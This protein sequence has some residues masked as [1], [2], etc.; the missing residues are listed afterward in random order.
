MTL[1]IRGQCRSVHICMYRANRESE[2][3][4]RNCAACTAAA[5]N[6][7]A[8]A[9][10]QACMHH[11][12]CSFPFDYLDMYISRHSLDRSLGSLADP[13]P[14]CHILPFSFISFSTEPSWWLSHAWWLSF[15]TH[16]CRLLITSQQINGLL[17]LVGFVHL[18]LDPVAEPE[19]KHRGGQFA[20]KIHKYIG[21]REIC[22]TSYYL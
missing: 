4:A 11:S 18:C 6:S 12:E 16:T 9:Y 22:L 21:S 14:F 17:V 5:S 19:P 20:N 8:H 10:S 7:S 13:V 15:S 3:P 1:T 2:S